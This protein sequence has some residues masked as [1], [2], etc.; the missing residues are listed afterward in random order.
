MKHFDARWRQTMC[1][2]IRYFGDPEMTINQLKQYHKDHP[3]LPN[4]IVYIAKRTGCDQ[5]GQPFY[6]IIEY[7]QNESKHKLLKNNWLEMYRYQEKVAEIEDKKLY[8]DKKE[9]ESDCEKY[10]KLFND[11]E[12][13]LINWKPGD[14]IIEI[15]HP[16]TQVKFNLKL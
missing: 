11:Y 6:R 10:Q 2:D 9:F 7:L 3:S 15:E 14:D 13:A 5:F 8:V 16:W 4:E 12:D 1:I